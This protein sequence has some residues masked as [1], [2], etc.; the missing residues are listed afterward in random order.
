MPSTEQIEQIETTGDPDAEQPFV[1]AQAQLYAQAYKKA[2]GEIKEA[3]FDPEHV[4][5]AALRA[6]ELAVTL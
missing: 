4:H 3:V 2:F 6:M 5:A 1:I